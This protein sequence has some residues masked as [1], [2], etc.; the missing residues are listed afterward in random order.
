V[1]TPQ[2]G[3]RGPDHIDNFAWTC[4]FC[5]NKKKQQL[6]YPA[7]GPGTTRLFDPR[8]DTWS[9][10]FIFT[11]DYMVIW[12]RT[13]IGAATVAALALNDLRP[14][15]IARQRFA[16]IKAE[17]YPPEWARWFKI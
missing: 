9:E 6:F 13:P 14:D 8:Y 2:H 5:N 16:E 4:P 15:S 17:T 1:V 10:H 7:R 3:R 11:A 12:G